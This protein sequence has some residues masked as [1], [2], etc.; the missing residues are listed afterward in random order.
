MPRKQ[1]GYKKKGS[2]KN[3][4]PCRTWGQSRRHPNGC[5]GKR[6]KRGGRKKTQGEKQVEEFGKNENEQFPKRKRGVIGVTKG[7]RTNKGD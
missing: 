4:A 3:W 2:V 7:D 5:K 1:E 6:K